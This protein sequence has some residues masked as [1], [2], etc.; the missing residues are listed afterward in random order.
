MSRKKPG[1]NAGAEFVLFDVTYEDGTQLSNRR[2]PAGI[3]GGLDKD[4]PALATIEAEDRKI[5][6][7][8]GKPRGKIKSIRRSAARANGAEPRK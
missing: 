4:E 6:Q 7:L 5:G 3:L 1:T 8:S 2:V